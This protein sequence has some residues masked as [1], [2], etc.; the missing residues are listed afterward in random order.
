MRYWGWTERRLPVIPESLPEE[1]IFLPQ[2][3][4]CPKQLRI[5]RAKSANPDMD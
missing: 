1:K 3:N 2:S 5:D 4:G